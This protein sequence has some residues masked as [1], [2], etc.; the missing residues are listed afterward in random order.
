MLRASSNTTENPVRQ[1]QDSVPRYE[2]DGTIQFVHFANIPDKSE[3][4][5]IEFEL[6]TIAERKDIFSIVVT[7][8]RKFEGLKS[9]PIRH[10]FGRMVVERGGQLSFVDYG[11]PSDLQRQRDEERFRSDFRAAMNWGYGKEYRAWGTSP[12]E[13]A[14]IS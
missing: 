9:A 1:N 7:L 4:S 5:S 13:S 6:R 3:F 10:Q 11:M 2:R 8:P 12:D 14:E